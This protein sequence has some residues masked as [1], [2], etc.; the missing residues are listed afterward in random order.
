M[1][2]AGTILLGLLPSFMPA[3]YNKE[4]L[5]KGIAYAWMLIIG[6]GR[7]NMGAHFASDVVMGILLSLVIF[8]VARA[9]VCKARKEPLPV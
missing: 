8:E 3:L 5:M 1:N 9:I 7:L 6:I 4:K 2:A